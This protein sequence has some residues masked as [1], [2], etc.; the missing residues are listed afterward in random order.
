MTDSR[1]NLLSEP[2]SRRGRPD[3]ALATWWRRDARFDVPASLVVFLVAVPLSLGIAVASG[4][5]VAAGLIAAA[6][7]GIV[8]GLTG[9]SP[10]QVSGPAAGLTVIVAETINTF[11]FAVTCAITAA[12]GVLQIALGAGRVGRYALAISPTVVRAMLAGIGLSILLGQLNVALGGSSSPTAW[13]NVQNLPAAFGDAQWQAA[14][15]AALV[16]VTLLAWPRLPARVK[17]VPGP[18]VAVVGATVVAAVALPDATRVDLGGSILSQVGL[19]PMPDGSWLALIGA[20]VTMTLI[21][22]VESLLSA[23]AVDRLQDGP[24][25]QLDRELV[26]QGLANSASGLIGGLPITGV[27]V[28]SATNVAAGARTRASAVLHGVWVLVFSLLLVGLVEQ[29]PLAALAGLLVVM[30]IQLVKPADMAEARRDG[31]LWIYVATAG[32]VLALN[33][34]E[35]VMIGLAATLVVILWRIMRVRVEATRHG[36]APDGREFWI[37]EVRGTLSFLSTPRL[38]QGLGSVPDG[39]VVEVDLLVDYLDTASEEQLEQWRKRYEAA[40]GQVVVERSGPSTTG[41]EAVIAKA[42]P[43]TQRAWMPW[44]TWQTPDDDRQIGAARHLATGIR[45]F[46]R[47]TADTIRPSLERMRES[48]H[49]DAFF[50]SCTDSRVVPNL[51]T[52]SGPGDLFTV[53]T[54]GNIAPVDGSSDASVSAPLL[55]AVDQLEVPS[56]VVCGHS[57]CG[58][59]TASLSEAAPTGPIAQWLSHADPVVEAWRGG[60]PVGVAA[61]AAG[62]GDVDQLAQVNVAMTLDRLRAELGPERSAQVSFVGLFFRVADGTV[63]MLRGDHFVPLTDAEMVEL[64]G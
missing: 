5:P 51:L 9:G 10:L 50:L 6:V 3:R 58:A 52:S 34:V 23:V 28:R 12:A 60:H 47:R 20:V 64:A 63:W 57:G 29:I 54:M 41:D 32:C 62:D 21:A 18:L 7:G 59:M 40:G 30:G 48:Q 22:S 25:S 31:E 16:I 53:R 33:L 13:E 11:G 2:A 35:G 46:H 1:P 49:P 39:Q 27:I 17:V 15:A 43:L 14:A 24:R 56:I 38:V 45:E 55:F 19:P 44:S 37:V 26:G 8:A 42:S 36:D 4:A 61:A